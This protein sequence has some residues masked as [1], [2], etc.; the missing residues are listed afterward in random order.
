MRILTI[1]TTVLFSAVLWTAQA[2]ADGQKPFSAWAMQIVN[3]QEV[4]KERIFVSANGIRSEFQDRGREMVRIV[5]PK[6]KLMRILFPQEK[7]YFELQAPADTP[8]SMSNERKPCPD[9][10][11]LVCEKVGKAVFGNIPVEQWKQTHTP[12]KT[13]SNMWW[14]PVRKIAVRQEFPDGR[15]MQLT[16]EG[17]V[18]FDGRSVENWKVTMADK[19]GKTAEAQRYID[20][21]LGIIVKEH[22]ASSGISRELRKLKV[23]ASDQGWFDVPAGYQRSEAPQKPMGQGR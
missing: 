1:I 3:G 17:N 7:V 8:A 13:S 14:E 5:L 10:E 23:M 9:V 16:L 2:H 21:G 12:T 15:I 22:D 19:D 11:G 6:L 20:M 4:H 18:D